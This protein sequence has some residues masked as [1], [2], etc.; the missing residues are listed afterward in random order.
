MATTTTTYSP[1]LDEV[2]V[3]IVGAGPAGLSAALSIQ[4]HTHL[5]DPGN[6][7]RP[8]VLLVDALPHGQ[9][10]SRALVIHARTLEVHT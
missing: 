1:D 3:L 9:N 6:S 5:T 8:K 4:H 10:E 2:D 7:R